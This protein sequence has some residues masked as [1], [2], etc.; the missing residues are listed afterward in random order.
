VIAYPTAPRP[1]NVA[2]NVAVNETRK[3]ERT[4]RLPL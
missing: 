1:A 3:R 2:S 4:A